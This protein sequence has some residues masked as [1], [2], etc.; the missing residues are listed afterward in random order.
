MPKDTPC[1]LQLILCCML[2]W[3]SG[4]A[5]SGSRTSKNLGTFI[6]HLLLWTWGVFT[7]KTSNPYSHTGNL[8]NWMCSQD[9]CYNCRDPR[10][11]VLRLPSHLR[12]SKSQTTLSRQVANTVIGPFAAEEQAVV[13]LNHL[14]WYIPSAGAALLPF[15][16][17][18]A[19]L[20]TFSCQALVHS[21]FSLRLGGALTV[22]LTVSKQCVYIWTA[23]TD[24][25][26]LLRAEEENQLYYT[27]I[28]QPFATCC[29]HTFHSTAIFHAL[30][31]ACISCFPSAGKHKQYGSAWR[32]RTA[33]LHKHFDN[34][35][36]LVVITAQC[37]LEKKTRPLS[38]FSNVVHT[39]ALFFGR[40]SAIQGMANYI[41]LK[42]CRALT[43]VQ[44]Q[45][46]LVVNRYFQLPK[47]VVN[48]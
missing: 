48:I 37:L 32:W 23:L 5:Y 9:L 13:L 12:S 33:S 3:L 44:G 22:F 24:S 31:F 28:W 2:E 21:Q 26:L 35:K 45:V 43:D 18:W 14:N 47:L 42:S 11:V 40:Y 25:T 7:L 20:F 29:G 41:E 16:R 46:L 36:D 15:L 34:K 38:K 19:R 10:A 39:G 17:C 30:L 1:P 4:A 8:E 6:S 27:R